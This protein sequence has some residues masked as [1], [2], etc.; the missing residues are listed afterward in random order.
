MTVHWC[1]NCLIRPATL[2]WGGEGGT[3]ALVHGMSVRWCEYCVTEAQLAYARERAAAIP[4][5]EAKF[6]RLA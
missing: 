4:D 1:Q 5:L 3:L 6:A 2:T